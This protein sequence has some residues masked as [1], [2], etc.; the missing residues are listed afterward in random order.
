MNARFRSTASIAT[1]KTRAELL[2]RA[3]AF[4]DRNQFFEVQTPL[5][6]V[7]TVVDRHLDPLPV[8]FPHDAYDLTS[9]RD[10]WLQSSP[11]FAMKRLLAS[12][13]HA[14]YQIAP[15]FRIGESGRQHNG[16]FTMLEWYRCG[17]GMQEGIELL[18]AFVSELLALPS[19][20]VQTMSQA[21]QDQLNFDPLAMDATQLRDRCQA[22]NVV[23]PESVSEYD[24]DTWFDLLFA[25]RVQPQL[26][27]DR[28][29]IVHSY[30]VSQ[31]ALA[32]VS[33]TNPKSA[34]RFEL[35]VHGVELANGYHEL[36]D[37]DELRRRNRQ[38]NQQRSLDGKPTLPVDSH[39]LDA[40][41]SGLP[42]CS[43][44]A[45][46]FDRLVMLATGASR[47]SDVIPFPM[48]RA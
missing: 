2:R 17:D 42:A 38:V 16:E 15:A 14:I 7:D 35:F 40:M 29:S 33:P 36:L 46:G 1:L 8:L 23:A 27:R 31:A 25:E 45:L 48:D 5:L 12:G 30:P 4:F 6:S 19:A 21:F 37:P 26:G 44:T 24:W 34:E 13:A 3:R 41:Q 39:L 22:L 10:M 32:R 9:G 20:S 18:D 47:I 11:E 28:P 43:G